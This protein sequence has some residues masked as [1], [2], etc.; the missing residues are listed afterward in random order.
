MRETIA[1]FRLAGFAT[2]GSC[3]GHPERPE[4]FPYI[5]VQA[6]STLARLSPSERRARVL[7]AADELSGD[8]RERLA[9]QSERDLL[10]NQLAAATLRRA[11]EAFYAS[12]EGRRPGPRLELAPMLDGAVLLRASR[13]RPLSSYPLGERAQLVAAER[14]ELQRFGRFLR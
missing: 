9:A 10:S 8:E 6:A 13:A 5:G 11:L 1:A 2:F 4:T 12:A 3:E 7:K 14:A